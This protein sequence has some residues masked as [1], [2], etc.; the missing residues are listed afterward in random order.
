[1]NDYFGGIVHQDRMRTL[2]GEA[3]SSRLAALGPHGSRRRVVTRRTLVL[4]VLIL[5]AFSALLQQVIA[6]G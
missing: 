5:I 4:A 3:D 1:M 6:A 2:R